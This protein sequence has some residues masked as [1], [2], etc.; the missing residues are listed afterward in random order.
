LHLLWDG[1]FINAVGTY[2]PPRVRGEGIGQY[3]FYDADA[4]Y[5][6]MTKADIPGYAMAA[7]AAKQAMKRSDHCNEALSTIVY[8]STRL[9]T[10]HATPV[11]HIQRILHQENALAFDLDA[12]SNGGLAGVEAVGR[13][14]S[15]GRSL[16]SGLLVTLMSYPQEYPRFYQRNLGGL[17]IGDGAAAAVISKKSGFA[18]LI[19][20]QRSTIPDFEVLG[21]NRATQPGAWAMDYF[22]VE[23]GPYLGMIAHVVETIISTTL[24][25]ANVAIED[26]SHFCLQAFPIPALQVLYLEQN[27]IPIEKTCW[28]ELRKNGH[29]G[30]CDE[31][32]GIAHLVDTDQLKSGQF[33]LLAGGG[34]GFR[35]SC[36]LLQIV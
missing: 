14:L 33:V 24:A 1:I 2:L 32:L 13:M 16:N 28:S 18:Q 15:S 35:L 12:A 25:E 5:E 9:T 7:I 31:L 3:E 8:A 34:M 20:S 22:E 30:P 19:A 10:D 21:Q 6:S 26:I 27:K 4:D 11:C 17:L 29:V 23:L 36:L